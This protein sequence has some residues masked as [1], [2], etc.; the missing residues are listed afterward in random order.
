MTDRPAPVEPWTPRQVEQK[1]A[2]LFNAVAQGELSMRKVLEQEADAKLEYERAHV[3]AAMDPNCPIPTRGGA[4]VGERD[5]WIRGVVEDEFRGYEYAQLNVTMQKRYLE[6]L[7]RQV[8]IV[9]TM[10]K[11]VLAAYSLA[12]TGER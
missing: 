10:S 12:G 7:E 5:S 8:S 4:T 9:Q 11:M 1:L 2:E 6:R 3:I